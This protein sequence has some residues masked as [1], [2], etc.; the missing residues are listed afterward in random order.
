MNV[1]QKD[2]ERSTFPLGSGMLWHAR[3]PHGEQPRKE[4]APIGVT[5]D[6]ET[7]QNQIC[8]TAS[9]PLLISL[10]H[11]LT[12]TFTLRHPDSVEDR[13]GVLGSRSELL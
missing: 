11:S 8:P 12:H 9:T 10:T 3:P 2:A 13:G 6:I 5:P 1:L 4:K 7:N